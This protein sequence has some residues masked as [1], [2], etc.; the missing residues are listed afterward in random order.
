MKDAELLYSLGTQD[1][2]EIGWNCVC[3]APFKTI[4][5][6]HFSILIYTWVRLF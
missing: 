5:K 1:E 6:I 2:H 3:Y 4:V